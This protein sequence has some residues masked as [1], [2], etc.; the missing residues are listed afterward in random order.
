MY[1]LQETIRMSNLVLYAKNFFN[2][3]V[4]W[5]LCLCWQMVMYQCVQMNNYF[6]PVTGI[7]HNRISS[8]SQYNSTGVSALVP[9]FYKLI[10]PIGLHLPITSSLVSYKSNLLQNRI[11]NI[12]YF[13]VCLNLYFIANLEIQYY[14]NRLHWWYKIGHPINDRVGSHT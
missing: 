1:Y 13:F 11:F 2:K 4:Y 14:N 8:L 5:T 12:R 7:K 6:I 10:T 3:V 9:H